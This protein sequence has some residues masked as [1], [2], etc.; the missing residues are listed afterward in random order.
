MVG[1]SGTVLQTQA[2]SEPIPIFPSSKCLRKCNI[3]QTAF[4]ATCRYCRASLISTYVSFSCAH[5][6]TH[7]KF[8]FKSHSIAICNSN[9]SSRLAKAFG[10]QI[11][12]SIFPLFRRRFQLWVLLFSPSSFPSA[13][14][15]QHPTLPKT[16]APNVNPT[17][18]QV[19]FQPHLFQQEAP[20]WWTLLHFLRNRMSFI[21]FPSR[22][23]AMWS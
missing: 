10:T 8:Q 7:Y 14:P 6:C 20:L 2:P 19:Q 22:T 9:L 4:L 3:T 18:F 17:E 1:I 21:D 16:L 13:G 12:L 11:L 5:F 23:T 15:T